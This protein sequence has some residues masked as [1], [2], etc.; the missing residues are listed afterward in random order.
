MVCWWVGKKLISYGKIRGT[1]DSSSLIFLSQ[2]SRNTYILK[3][4][5]LDT[6][7]SGKA[8]NQIKGLVGAWFT[9]FLGHQQGFEDNS[10]GICW[11]IVQKWN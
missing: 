5:H 11:M 9:K 4:E 6:T 8:S 10:H 3:R 1:D 7:S 2:D